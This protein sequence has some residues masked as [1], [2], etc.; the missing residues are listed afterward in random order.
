MLVLLKS[1]KHWAADSIKGVETWYYHGSKKGQKLA[2][3]FQKHILEQTGFKNRHL[4]SRPQ[5]QFYV[6]RK[7]TM[8]SVLTENGFY[9]NKRE[10][11]E[12]MK[13]S[14]RQK[15]ADAHIASILEIEKNGII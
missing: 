3:V 11:A 2:S 14:I 10:A 8:T 1:S 7:T 15:I 13:P 9:N 5:S 12:L 4:K 6:L